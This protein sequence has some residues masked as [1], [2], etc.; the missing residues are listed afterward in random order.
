MDRRQLALI[1]GPQSPFNSSEALTRLSKVDEQQM[2][3]GMERDV[4][5][6]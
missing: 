1:Y 2:L 5:G 3:E 4:I 6:D